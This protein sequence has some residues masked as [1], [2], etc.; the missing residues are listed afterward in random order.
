MKKMN[1]SA[2][3]TRYIKGFPGPVQER[4]NQTREAIRAVADKAEELISYKL[5]AYK[6]Q[7]MLVYFA[8]YENHIGFYPTP[9]AIA[10]FKRELSLYKSAKGSVQFPHESPLPVSLIKRMVAFRV[11]E[12]EA[13]AA[14]K[15]LQKQK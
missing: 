7:G 14:L 10:H 8:A 6:Y 1:T 9:S 2:E 12:N 15:L 11:A 3:V 13:K 5:P 4:L